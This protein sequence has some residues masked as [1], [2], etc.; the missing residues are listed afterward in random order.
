MRELTDNLYVSGKYIAKNPTL[1][2]EDSAWKI[3]KILPLLYFLLDKCLRKK[4]ISLLDVGG[5]AGLILNAVTS[6]IQ[7]N[8]RCADEY[9]LDLSLEM[10]KIQQRHNSGSHILNEDI[11]KTSFRYKSIDLAL[12][13]DVLEHVPQPELALIELRRI[14]N[15]VILKV[16]L[17][18]NLASRALDLFDNGKHRQE[19]IQKVG[20]V[21][22]YSLTRLLTL[23]E[24][25]LGNILYV[26]FTD[27]FEYILNKEKLGFFSKTKA[28]IGKTAY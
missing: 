20:H 5:G 9:S 11:R 15:Y 1:H 3:E 26:S 6:Y 19:M 18:G 16:P 23:I 25:Y 13:I 12:M 22:L 10:L 17:E 21:N 7:K 28:I 14:A 4:Q 2:E 27:Q 24:A 8:K